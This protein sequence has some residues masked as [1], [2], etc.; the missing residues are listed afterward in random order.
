MEAWLVADPAGQPSAG[1]ALAPAAAGTRVPQLR[2]RLVPPMPGSAF[3]GWAGPLL[4]TI[5]GAFLRFYRLGSPHAVIFDETYYVPDAY[6]IL[7]HG[8][9]ID[10]VKNVNALLVHG[11]THFLVGT[12]GE[13]VVHPPLGKMLIAVGEWLFGLTPFGW[14][15]AVAV[16]GSLAI[17]MTARIARRMTRSTLLGCIAGLLLALDGLEFVLSRTA[18]LDI[19]VMFWVLA[20]FGMIVIDRDRTRAQLAAAAASAEPGDPGGPR[21][22][23]RWRLLLAGIFLG[24]ACASK[25]NGLWYIIAFGALVIAWDLGA[26]RAAGF[27]PRLAG[28]LRS[29]GPWLPVWFVIAP[30]IVYVASWSGWFATSYGYDRNGAALNGGHPASTIVAW[31]QYNKSMLNFGLGLHSSSPYESNPVGWLVLARPTAFYSVCLPKDAC[32]GA[33]STLQ[34]VLAIGTPL[35]WWAGCLALL[36][37]L[38]WWLTRRDWRPGAVLLSV[39]AGWLPWIWFYWH[40]H[41]TEFYF[42]AVILDPF[43]VIAITLCLGLI[44]GPARPGPARRVTAAA[45]CGAYLLAVLVNFAYLY[46]ILAGQVLP[47]SSWLGRMWF[48]SWI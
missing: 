29:D 34:E 1:T 16:T 37:C 14:R 2:D 12:K 36:V 4:V 39:A 9:E 13:Y 35:I 7:K 15:F 5:F 18:I 48:S 47:Y 40:D 27:E 28:V 6:G 30:A 3:W 41:R 33:R 8:V 10:H 42:Y 26:R 44:I 22:G 11:S 21:L 25:W 43:L 24:C 23:F 32:G 45:I 17:L 19:F 20:A 38:G 46:P 31:L